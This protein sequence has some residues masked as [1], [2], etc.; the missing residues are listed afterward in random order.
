MQNTPTAASLDG[1]GGLI[2][3][4]VNFPG[5]FRRAAYFVDKIFKGTKPE[6]IPVEQP[7]VFDLAINMNTAK[8]LGVQ[9]P[10]SLLLRATKVIE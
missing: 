10:Y 4:G 8:A 7:T 3:Y 6:D 2:D 1:A 9:I 5:L